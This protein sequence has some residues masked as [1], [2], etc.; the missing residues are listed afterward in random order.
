MKVTV[1][2]PRVQVHKVS[3][4]SG[5]QVMVKGLSLRGLGYGP[6]ARVVVES[7]ADGSRQKWE[8]EVD[9]REHATMCS[10]NPPPPNWIRKGEA[11][12]ISVT[13]P[14]AADHSQP[15]TG[16][17][18]GSRQS[19][20]RDAS[21][22]T[23]CAEQTPQEVMDALRAPRSR[24]VGG[25][26]TAAFD[27]Y[28]FSDYSG[29]TS[30][31]AAI[32]PAIALHSSHAVVIAGR[33]TR[34]TLV[35]LFMDLL[36]AATA[37]GRR[38][39]LGVDHQYGIPLPFGRELGL[40]TF[41][42]RSALRELRDGSAGRPPLPGNQGEAARALNGWLRTRGKP[43]YFWS[44][45]QASYGVPQTD[46]RPGRVERR[47]LTEERIPGAK[48]FNRVG[49]NGSVGGQT[50]L[51]LPH[52]LDL[53]DRC[54][55]AHVEVAA[56]PFDGVK[57]SDSVYQGRHVLIELYPSAIRPADVPQSDRADAVASVNYWQALDQAGTL[58]MSADLSGLSE[59]D[60]RRVRFEGWILNLKR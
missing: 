57:L 30:P 5:S 12:R 4:R 47:R 49:D 15:A 2:S 42:W 13:P 31:G 45:T 27:A 17:E 58:T 36:R 35:D 44:A 46:P 8:F 32:V 60:Q 11:V 52:L 55:E 28:V 14:A 43:D 51:G 59:E 21:P 29:A 53:L 26:T 6:G 1:G 40:S 19:A 56:W 50:L 24:G 3:N 18:K 48:T 38:V 7:C 9:V 34:T 23:Q 54:R 33:F 16:P 10:R 22:E 39:V 20:P 37:G 25:S 41:D